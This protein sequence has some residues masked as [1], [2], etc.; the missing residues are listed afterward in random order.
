MPNAD[1]A[2][3]MC[4]RGKR[5]W[6]CGNVYLATRANVSG[7]GFQIRRRHGLG[8]WIARQ[9]SWT[10]PPRLV[11]RFE[12]ASAIDATQRGLVMMT[13]GRM[14]KPATSQAR[15]GQHAPLSA[16]TRHTV[17]RNNQPNRCA[18]ITALAHVFPGCVVT[19]IALLHSDRQSCR[20][21]VHCNIPGG[22]PN[23]PTVRALM[24]F[25][26]HLQLVDPVRRRDEFSEP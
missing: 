20:S 21:M 13:S 5:Y 14:T 9:L 10:D 7:S 18:L 2:A 8:M 24:R 15:V 25:L 1:A 23:L 12:Q 22:E 26:Q 19:V 3:V 11:R 4:W 6:A 16:H 17:R